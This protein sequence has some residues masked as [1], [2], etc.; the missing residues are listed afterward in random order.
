MKS[1]PFRLGEGFFPSSVVLL[2]TCA[3]LNRTALILLVFL[4]AFGAVQTPA[5][6]GQNATATSL[7][8]AAG[9]SAATSV[10]SGTV[11]TLTAS[12]ANGSTPITTGQVDFC[13]ATANY[14]TD[15]HLLGAVQLTSG[16]TAVLRF[17]PA[18]GE[19]APVTR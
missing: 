4:I 13:D 7:S 18:P 10:S 1:L 6:F 8:V 9:G 15:V 11:V 3:R 16:G 12:V 5:V 17:R 2:K 19:P 14:C